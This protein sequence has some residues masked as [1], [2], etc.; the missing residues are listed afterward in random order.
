VDDWTVEGLDQRVAE[1]RRLFLDTLEH[2]P[3]ADGRC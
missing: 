2:W 1:V 3:G